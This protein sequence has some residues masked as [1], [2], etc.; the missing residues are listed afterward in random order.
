MQPVA[1]TYALTPS[2]DLLLLTTEELATYQRDDDNA[3]NDN[4]DT[5]TLDDSVVPPTPDTSMPAAEN[6]A[7]YTA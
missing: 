4:L 7:P 5:P 3:A 2:N 1:L 6:E